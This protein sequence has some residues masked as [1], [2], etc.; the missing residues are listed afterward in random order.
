MAPI[1]G[2][3]NPGE[4]VLSNLCGGAASRGHQPTACADGT[5]QLTGQLANHRQII[6]FDPR[7]AEMTRSAS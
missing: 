7:P 3:I 5:T 2:N 1:S 4:T 6:C